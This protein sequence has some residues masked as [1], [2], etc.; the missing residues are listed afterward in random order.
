MAKVFKKAYLK[1][2]PKAN[3]F[4]DVVTGVQIS[5]KQVIRLHNAHDLKH[6]SLATA[7]Q[8]NHIVIAT[9]QEYNDAKTM[10]EKQ[11]K[12]S[13]KNLKK[14]VMQVVKFTEAKDDEEPEE[15]VEEL[16]TD[17]N[18]TDDDDDDYSQDTETEDTDD[19][20]DSVDEEP[21]T[22]SELIDALKENPL[23]KEDQKKKLTQLGIKKLQRLYDT[24]KGK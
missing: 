15:E 8:T 14:P 10:H 22:K 6:K 23:I 1:L 7:L 17:I 11:V 12:D 3:T 19:D 13:Q 4:Y 9:E 5:N 18:D 24:I 21:L 20:D 2:G 16:N